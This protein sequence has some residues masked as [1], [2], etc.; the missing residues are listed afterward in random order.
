MGER[1]FD[2]AAIEEY[3]ELLLELLDELEGEVIPVLATGTLS[4]APAFGAAPGA[5][6]DAAGRYL[7]FHAAAWR[8]LQYLRGTLRGMEA[9]LAQATSGEEDAAFFFQFG[10]AE[11]G[12]SDAPGAPGV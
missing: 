9:A 10:A 11:P 1:V 4:R 5:A 2:P 12:A 3:R 7:G 6:E 8:H